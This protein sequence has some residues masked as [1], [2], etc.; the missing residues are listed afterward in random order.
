VACRCQFTR[1]LVLPG[2]ERDGV[3]LLICIACVYELLVQ[4]DAD[5]LELLAR[6]QWPD[7]QQKALQQLRSLG[8]VEVQVRA[9]VAVAVLAD[10]LAGWLAGWLAHWWL[11]PLPGAANLHLHK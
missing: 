10:G 7:Q 9:A 2:G 8:L 3:T 11:L 1:G 5:A 6:L 4:T